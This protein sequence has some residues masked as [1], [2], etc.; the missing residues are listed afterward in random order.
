MPI[1][2]VHTD[3]STEA[4]GGG[5]GVPL[6]IVRPLERSLTHATVEPGAMVILVTDGV[7]ESRT[8]DLDEGIARLQQRA[9][10]L[11]GLPLDELVVALA[12]LSDQ[13]LRDDV[14]VVA[15]RRR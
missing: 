1:V 8:H 12:E 10:E 9:S 3:G 6:G 14:T 4:L 11:R 7:V 15:A 5:S 2:I 13:S